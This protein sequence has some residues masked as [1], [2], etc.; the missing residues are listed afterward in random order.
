MDIVRCRPSKTTFSGFFLLRNDDD[1]ADD[2]NDDGC[3]VGDAVDDND[4]I[5]GDCEGLAD[6][7]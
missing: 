7:H 5:D 6:S 1:D 3:G 4:S 2:A